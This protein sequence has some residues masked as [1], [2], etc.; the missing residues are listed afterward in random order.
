MYAGVAS[1]QPSSDNDNNENENE[2]STITPSS[3]PTTSQPGQDDENE[4]NKEEDDFES[5]LPSFGGVRRVY[6]ES[7]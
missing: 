2:N 5:D 3:I 1:T 6:F 7:M 4:N